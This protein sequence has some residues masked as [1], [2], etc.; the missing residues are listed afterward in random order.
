MRKTPPFDLRQF[1]PYLLNHAAEAVSLEFQ[2]TYKGKYGMLRTEWRV[3]FHLGQYG[4]MPARQICDMARLHKTKVS[5]AVAA[6]EEK[7]FLTRK[8]LAADRRHAVLTLTRQGRSVFA[9]LAREARAFDA[10]IRAEMTEEESEVL[11]RCLK[12]IAKFEDV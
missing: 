8:E 3:L 12:R 1:L 2:R 4:D 10:R 6:L 9:D 5:R 11:Q 7:R